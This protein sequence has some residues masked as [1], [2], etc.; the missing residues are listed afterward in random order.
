M[1]ELSLSAGLKH[2]HFSHLKTAGRD[3]FS[4]LDR[5]LELFEEARS[6]G[7]NV[8]CDRYPYTESMTQ[9]SVSLPGKWK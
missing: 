2:F 1:I 6:R 4:K 7:L 8:T 3:N 5:L 9:L